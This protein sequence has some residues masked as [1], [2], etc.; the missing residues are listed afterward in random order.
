MPGQFDAIY[1]LA[2]LEH[3]NDPVETMRTFHRLIRPGGVLIFDYIKSDAEGLDSVEGL[4]DRAA[5][6]RFIE[7][8]FRLLSGRL[9]GEQ[10][11]KLTVVTPT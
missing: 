1:C 4:R 10:S 6:L 8:N 2:V 5:A 7:G 9:D 11:M 3:V